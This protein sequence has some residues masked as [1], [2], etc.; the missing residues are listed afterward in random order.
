M[1]ISSESRQNFQLPLIARLH[2]CPAKWIRHSNTPVWAYPKSFEDEADAIS[3]CSSGQDVLRRV[4]MPICDQF[5]TPHMPKAAPAAP[6][7]E[8][9]ALYSESL[10]IIG[11]RLDSQWPAGNP[12]QQWSPAIGLRLCICTPLL[13]VSRQAA[14]DQTFIKEQVCCIAGQRERIFPDQYPH[15]STGTPLV[16]IV[17][18]LA[19]QPS[20]DRYSN[21]MKR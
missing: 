17:D 16:R 2:T 15:L 12:K 4:P 9:V 20:A 19:N 8:R 21:S 10:N 1:R 3:Y 13:A 5:G 14:S 7:K 18:T 6:I 11:I